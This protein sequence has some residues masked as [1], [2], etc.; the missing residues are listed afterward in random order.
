MVMLVDKKPTPEE[1][2]AA[3]SAEGCDNLKFIVLPES[4]FT[5]EKIGRKNQVLQGG[6]Y[7]HITSDA[8]A[9]QRAE[10]E[11]WKSTR[12]T[13]SV[14]IEAQM[15]IRDS[16]GDIHLSGVQNESDLASAIVQRLPNVLLQKIR[17]R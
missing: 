6:E 14:S 4:P 7:D 17:R 8:L 5:I 13:D 11:N 15:C 16:I 10:Y 2:A 3:K 1:I 9:M 12:L